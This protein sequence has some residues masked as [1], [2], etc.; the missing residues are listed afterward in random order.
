MKREVSNGLAQRPYARHRLLGLVLTLA[1]FGMVGQAQAVCTEDGVASTTGSASG[2]TVVCT[3]TINNSGPGAV[4]GYGSATDTNNS[5][6]VTG[7]LTGTNFGLLAN[8][9]GPLINTGA[10]DGV[11]IAG[12]Q[13]SLV[14]VD[15]GTSA[16]ILGFTTGAI[17]LDTSVSNAGSIGA[18]GPGS[19]A[20]RGR[21]LNLTSNTGAI[22]AVSI[23]IQVD[24]DA[25]INNTGGIVATGVTGVGILVSKDNAII[26]ASGNASSGTIK[27]EAAGISVISANATIS[28]GAG[29]ITGSAATGIGIKALQNVTVSGNLGNILGSAFGILANGGTATVTNNGNIA[30]T[31]A[32]IDALTANVTNSATGTIVGQGA[33]IHGT[34][35]VT[36]NNAHDITANGANGTAVSSNGT[37]NIV[38]NSGNISAAG[39][40]GTAIFGNAG[41][42]NITA[43]SGAI[44]GDITG[45]LADNVSV[46]ANTGTIEATAA[47]GFGIH[48]TAMANLT[49]AG[50]IRANGTNGTAI[51][52]DTLTLANSGTIQATGIGGGAIGTFSAT[53]TNSGTISGTTFGISTTT[54]TVT[55][56]SGIIEAT[57]AGGEALLASDATVTNSASGII[58]ANGANAVAIDASTGTIVNAG[59]IEANGTGGRAI[60]AGSPTV[61]NSVGGTIQANGTN[62]IAIQV[63]T[64]TVTNAGTIQANGLDGLAF[65]AAN[66]DLTNSGFVKA[67][68]AGGGAILTATGTLTNSGTIS[69]DQ[70]AIFATGNFT[71]AANSGVIE[72]TGTNGFAISADGATVNNSASGIIRATGTGATVGIFA[73]KG[74]TV[75]NAGSISGAIGIQA[76]GVG[77]IGSIITNSG[78]IAG[79]G[80][81]A[82]KLSNAADT[83]TLLPGSKIVGLIDMG[84]NNADVINAFAAIPTSRVSSLTTGVTL[85]TVINFTGTLNTGF[86]GSASGPSVQSATQVATLD[87]TALAQTDRTL[88]DFTGGASSLVQSRLNGA[89]SAGGSMMAMAYAPE[90]ANAGPFPKAPAADWMNPAPITVWVNSF[91]G[92]RVQDETRSTLRATSTAWGAAMGIDRR[93][94]PD[95]LVGAFIGGGSGDLSVDLNSQTVKTDYVFG[96]GYSRFEWASQFLDVTVQVGSASNKSR[97]LVLN[98]AVAGGSE[99]ATASY[100]GWYISPEVAYGFRYGLGDGYVLT[101]T[102]RLR[103]VAGKFD[104]YS[105]TGSAETL[106][107]GSRTLQNLEERG[108]LDVSKVMTFGGEHNLKANVHGGVIALQRVGDASIGALLVGQTLA[109]TTP[110][111]ASS[112]GAVFGAG[113]DYYIS[114]NVA[115]FGAVEGIAMSDQS[116]TATARG[117]LRVA[118]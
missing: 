24:G 43:N 47:N 67:T 98:N 110:G 17:L 87:P 33:G 104:G 41:T 62:G 35:L 46:N 102:A 92:R 70:F 34:N 5:Y 115:V 112:V 90:N 40:N 68:G 45:V 19:T 111:K 81:T 77:G 60:L 91:G 38:S 56:N 58:R 83:V 65:A 14:S 82:I 7:A 114:R 79:T 116:R 37:I 73:T 10:I 117:G 76:N 52:A 103:Y 107:I 3:G 95:W 64:A 31:L 84:G 13:G 101:P 106:K 71:V 15:N 57:G 42:V 109:F 32:G 80:G 29:V 108:E 100:N 44:S 22:S 9:G 12:V 53:V 28:N 50:T 30:G 18:T 61:T 118:F 54:L 21:N 4:T 66:I 27:G 113:F 6:T 55:G 75:V 26:N 78:T 49:S 74:A 69:A 86:T 1:S 23:G 20:I 8:S 93:V 96:G 72:A 99:T 11:T 63:G 97:R 36:V 39:A 105:E 89:P 94:R 59:N 25:T 51:D 2:K 88:M 48:A 85:P 16:I